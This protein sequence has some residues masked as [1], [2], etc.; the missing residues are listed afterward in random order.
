MYTQRCLR[1]M[2][3]TFTCL[4]NRR[5]NCRRSFLSRAALVLV[6][7]GGLPACAQD[8]GQA[9]LGKCA[10]LKVTGGV[11]C[12][13]IGGAYIYINQN[14]GVAKK[15]TRSETDTLVRYNVTMPTVTHTTGTAYSSRN[16]RHEGASS[17]PRPCSLSAP[18]SISCSGSLRNR[19]TG[20]SS[21]G[22]TSVCSGGSCISAGR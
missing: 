21:P 19:M 1:L 8:T 10:N 6:L 5:N 7:T 2:A 3:S 4:F 13:E 12:E 20:S 18:S 17:R 9:R 16:P 14:T 22:F 15:L 11:L